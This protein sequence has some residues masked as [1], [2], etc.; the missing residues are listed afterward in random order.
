[1]KPLQNASSRLEIYAAAFLV[2]GVVAFL[3]VLIV[4]LSICSIPKNSNK[5]T[6]EDF[7]DKDIVA[8]KA[9]I[10]E[11]LLNTI[12]RVQ[13]DVLN[14]PEVRAEHNKK[15]SWE[16]I[17]IRAEDIII[18]FYALRKFLEKEMHTPTWMSSNVFSFKTRRY[19]F[20]DAGCG[21]GNVL[22]LA[23]AV[24]LG[25][26]FHGLELFQ[27]AF[28]AAIKFTGARN[29]EH[30][31]VRVLKRDILKFK[32]YA[33][34]DIIYYFHPLRD[35]LKEIEFEK[36]VENDM[37]VGAILVP[38]MKH[39]FSIEKDPRFERLPLEVQHVAAWRKVRE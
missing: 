14:T 27:D 39:D 35:G 21:I 37:K 26:E 25:H 23:R 29:D 38:K 6:K 9:E 7:M 11:N 20:L 4:L 1:V 16:F 24:G 13:R 8:Y 3:P 5:T 17:P 22:L 15:G 30:S 32:S 34:Y 36:K 31:N 19:K 33:D 2:T 12:F 10:F 28:E 18:T